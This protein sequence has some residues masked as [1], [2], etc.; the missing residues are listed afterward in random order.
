M[1]GTRAKLSAGFDLSS[2]ADMAAKA[3]DILVID[4]LD[5]VSAELAYL[6]AGAKPSAAA[7][8]SAAGTTSPAKA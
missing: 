6:A 3:G 5:V 7:S 8:S 4:V 2:L 1:F